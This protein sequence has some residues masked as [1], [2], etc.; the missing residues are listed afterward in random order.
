MI[1]ELLDINLATT[2]TVGD[3]VTAIN[4]MTNA[5]ASINASGKIVITAAGA[6][7]VAFN[8]MSSAVTVGSETKG[9]SDF[10]GLNDFFTS[11]KE[12]DD[13]QTAFQSSNSTSL[14]IAG[15]LTFHQASFGTTAVAYTTGNSLSDIATAI[16]ANATLSTAGITASVIADGT[17]YRL[18]VN[19]NGA[20]NFFVTDTSTFVSSQNLKPRDPGTSDAG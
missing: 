12:Y 8:E 18:R 5:S 14:S 7:S 19:D 2:T 20:D 13:Y 17:G 3:L 10:L 15:T 4:G 16:N 11:A 1:V 6:N 9:A